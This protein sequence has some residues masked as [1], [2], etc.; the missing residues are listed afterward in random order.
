MRK[1]VERNVC[2]FAIGGQFLA[3][4]NTFSTNPAELVSVLLMHSPFI[5]VTSITGSVFSFFNQRSTIDACQSTL[6][7]RRPLLSQDL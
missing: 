6:Y 1:Q 5:S 4:A 2:Q 7:F 3:D